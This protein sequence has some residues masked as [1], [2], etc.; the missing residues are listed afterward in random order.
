M[1]AFMLDTET[2]R[3]LGE[4]KAAARNGDK[5]AARL[6]LTQ[7]VERDPHNEQAW[8]WLSGVVA[9]P[10]EQQICL[11][12][13]LVIN[14]HNTKARKGLEFI[15]AKTGM[16]PNIPPLAIA[17][18]DLGNPSEYTSPLGTSPLSENSL[19]EETPPV[20]GDSFSFSNERHSTSTLPWLQSD[21]YT[22]AP[23]VAQPPVF[24][25]GAAVN[26]NT[27]PWATAND[28]DGEEK[29]FDFFDMPDVDAM[30]PWVQPEPGDESVAGDAQNYG[31]DA[32]PAYAAKAEGITVP[33]DDHLEGV[34]FDVA[35]FSP[36]MDFPAY[37][38]Q[39]TSP[40]AELGLPEWSMSGV[41]PAAPQGSEFATSNGMGDV[42]A[43]FDPF[44]SPA[45]S[46]MGPMGPSF[47]AQLP[48]PS[49]LP[50]YTGDSDQAQP[51]YLQQTG[52]NSGSL[53]SIAM[54]NQGML[55]SDTQQPS[56][57][58]KEPASTIDCPNCHE[59][60][61]DT[62]LACSNCRYSFFVNCPNCHELV[63]TSDA[64]PNTTEPCPYCKAKIDRMAM[65]LDGTEGAMLY[66]SE[67]LAAARG[68]FPTMKDYVA[69]TPGKRGLSFRWM[70]DV[71]WLVVIV[72][73]VWALTQLPTWLHLTGQY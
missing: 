20:P 9:E 70:V 48:S 35:P 68:Q 42:P 69:A 25:P 58:K 10:E 59:K 4:G 62:A 39:G 57:G 51:W 67:G 49:D 46:S 72:M 60:A 47:D 40:G 64:R 41:L 50:G 12:N 19:H 16:A 28:P 65:G 5:N 32:L 63:D 34:N 21:D 55:A 27:E 23:D 43:P 22:D 8:M 37:A 44:G 15:S 52:D 33:P 73:T 6:L 45:G 53:S 11:E 24:S 66:K 7:V 18:L 71:L 2:E 29:K 17:D 3:L 56:R 30:P 38:G 54:P 36:D 1:K 14:P 13:V 26:E 31:G 61:P